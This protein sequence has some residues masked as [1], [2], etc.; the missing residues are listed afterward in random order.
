MHSV[1]L[2]NRVE[3]ERVCAA[4][5]MPLPAPPAGLAGDGA[6]PYAESGQVSR[7]AGRALMWTSSCWGTCTCHW[8]HSTSMF[9]ELRAGGI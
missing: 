6:C 2:A 5:R 8:P 7:G 9:L 4:T 1:A 3:V